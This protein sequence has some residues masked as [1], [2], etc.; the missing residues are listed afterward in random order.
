MHAEY[1]SF[2]R[3]YLVPSS[4][5]RKVT[6]LTEVELQIG[7]HKETMEAMVLDVGQSEMLI[8]YDWLIHHNPSVNWETGE[9]ELPTPGTSPSKPPP[10]FTKVNAN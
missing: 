4:S 3:S 8:G 10:L 2:A 5:Q 6:K 7:R 1:A 9:V